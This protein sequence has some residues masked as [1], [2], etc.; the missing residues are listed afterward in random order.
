M[1]YKCNFLKL[2]KGMYQEEGR[3]F[4]HVL[5][6]LDPSD[7]YFGT[8]FE[9]LDA[10]QRQLKR[11]DIKV[12][13]AGSD[14]VE[15]FFST[16]ESA[17][18]FPEF[19][20]RAVRH[21][22]EDTDVL[23]SITAS[24]S[25]HKS[26]DQASD[27]QIVFHKRGRMLILSYNAVRR[28]SLDLFSVV[29]RQIGAYIARSRLEDAVDVLINGDNNSDPAPVT[30][31]DLSD[32]YYDSVM[33]FWTQL[34]PYEMNIMLMSN[35]MAISF[36]Q[37]LIPEIDSQYPYYGVTSFGA[38]TIR[39]GVVPEGT[40]IGL[41][42]RFALEMVQIGDVNVDYEKLIDKQ[43]ER[44]AICVT[45]GFSKIYGDASIVLKVAD[46]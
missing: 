22:M 18:L 38:K 21:G 37:K 46:K 41:D 5:E 14:K 13:G 39:S 23:P 36:P 2:E 45:T 1:V 42:K 3:S 19:V 31:L 27:K 11:F 35:D 44:S 6:T 8:A 20:S 24:V 29:L 34:D 15:K 26:L 17:V 7:T 32:S 40:I 16:H 9:G 30:S 28:Q 10:F 43:F 4:S 12:R 25:K 33:K